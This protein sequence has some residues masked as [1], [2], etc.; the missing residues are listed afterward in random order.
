VAEDG[1]GKI[2]VTLLDV[3]R[4]LEGVDE[5][6]DA[7]IIEHERDHQSVVLRR[8][9]YWLFGFMTTIILALYSSGFYIASQVS[10]AGP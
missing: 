3:Y 9:M 6:L 10:A 1:N 4:K 2:V 8:E 7:R 5:K